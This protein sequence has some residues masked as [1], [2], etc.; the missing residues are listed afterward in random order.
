MRRPDSLVP[1]RHKDSVLLLVV[2]AIFF[3]NPPGPVV[4]FMGLR[5]SLLAMVSECFVS[6]NSSLVM[7]T[8]AWPTATGTI[9]SVAK[10]NYIL[11]SFLFYIYSFAKEI[12]CSISDAGMNRLKGSFRATFFI[13]L[14]PSVLS[15]LL[16]PLIVNGEPWVG[17][18]LSIKDVDV[19]WLGW[20]KKS[21]VILTVTFYLP[22]VLSFSWSDL[23][24]TCEGNYLFDK[25]SLRWCGI[26][27]LCRFSLSNFPLQPWNWS[28]KFSCCC[29]SYSWIIV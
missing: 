15:C 4:W 10:S 29:Q 20:M 21:R 25:M 5:D 3:I 9:F 17:R 23:F 28:A 14:K 26:L 24:V 13:R 1:G 7:I 6:L 27:D 12:R 16:C 8:L 19:C 18:F 22:E 11:L 2:V